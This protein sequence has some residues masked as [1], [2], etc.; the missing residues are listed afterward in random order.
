MPYALCELE[1]VVVPNAPDVGRRLPEV[2]LQ[3]RRARHDAAGNDGHERGRALVAYKKLRNRRQDIDSKV[4][5]PQLERN[6]I[7]GTWNFNA[8]DA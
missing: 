6:F 7:P 1:V 4:Y 3:K 2:D 8:S 5:D